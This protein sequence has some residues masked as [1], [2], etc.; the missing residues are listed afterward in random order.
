[1]RLVSHD[2]QAQG[3]RDQAHGRQDAAADVADAGQRRRWRRPWRC[4]ADSSAADHGDRDHAG[5]RAARGQSRAHGRLQREPPAGRRRLSIDSDI[6]HDGQSGPSR[7]ARSAQGNAAHVSR[8]RH[9]QHHGV[10]RLVEGSM[11]KLIMACA[12]GVTTLVSAENGGIPPAALYK[13]LGE[14]WPVYSGDYS[15]KRYSSL[16]QINQSNVK[17]LT[18]AW[19]RRLTNGPGTPGGG[20]GGGAGGNTAPVIVG[21]VGSDF[22]AGNTQLKGSI[23]QYNGILYVTAPDNVWALDGVDGREIWHYVWKTRGGTHIGNRGVGI[24]NNYLFFVTPDDY[25]I[26]L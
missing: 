24:W 7:P 8:F 2:G 13:P 23:L 12:I 11:K 20:F 18:L 9:S 14:S 21:G 17:N 19:T 26:S 4:A 10:P 5:R 1:M 15:G 3:V 6:R 16:T 25:L 22:Y